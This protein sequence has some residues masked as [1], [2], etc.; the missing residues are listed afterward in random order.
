MSVPSKNASVI[1]TGA[2]SGIGAEIARKFSE[3]GY[4]VFLLGRSAEK[5]ANV[6]KTC[7][8]P[9]QMMAFDLKNLES[10]ENLL[11]KNLQACPP[12]EI[13]INNA[14]IYHRQPFDQTQEATWSEQFEIN[15]LAPVRLTRILWPAFVKNKKG[16]ILNISSTLGLKPAPQTSAY[17]AVKAAMNNWTMSL[18][19]EGGEY[20]IRANAI[21]PGI[22]DTPIHSFHHLDP[23][24][25][26]KAMKQ[27]ASLQ[28][29]SSIGHPTQ[30]A[31]AAYFLASDQSSWTTGSILSVDGGINIK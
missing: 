13:L 22:V 1:I 29:L 8:G 10:T 17:S 16:S 11:V 12:L 19:Q 7:S 31:E 28:L 30:I 27:M 26:N 14:G 25:K 20:N 3:N 9:S 15:L 6:Q 23:E 21:C 24:D 2:S 5:L 4:F 18:A